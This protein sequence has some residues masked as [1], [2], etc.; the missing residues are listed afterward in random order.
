MGSIKVNGRKITNPLAR[1]LI[2]ATALLV[3]AFAAAAVICAIL[4]ATG[5]VF[6]I[7][8]LTVGVMLLYAAVRVVVTGR[9][10]F[11]NWNENKRR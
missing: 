6:A 10:Y 8:I 4:I 7:L 2:P 1:M 11:A 9:R 5:L 3:L